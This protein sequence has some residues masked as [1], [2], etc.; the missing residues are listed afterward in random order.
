M[1][2][3]DVEYSNLTQEEADI[4]HAAAGEPGT[5]YPIHRPGDTE[6]W[7]SR[8]VMDFI[9]ATGA[10]NVLETG[11]FQGSTSAW[12]LEGLRRLGGRDRS[13]TICEIEPTRAEAL[14]KRFAPKQP[15][16][17]EPTIYSGDIL[18]FLRS[19]RA[20]F[21]LAWV[22]DCHEE[23]HV[24]EEIALLYPRMRPGG[25]ILM[26]D[27]CGLCP[28]N[29]EPLGDICQKWGGY[30]LDIGRLGPAGGIGILQVPQ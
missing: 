24:R 26:H 2:V 8:L 7:V 14:S 19:T 28:G 11:G 17:L 29:H 9:I 13:F 6:R 21:D 4:R 12:I 18:Q 22:D 1:G 3:V 20:T 23:G 15:G 5:I 10:R 27:V 16:E 30:V 25:L